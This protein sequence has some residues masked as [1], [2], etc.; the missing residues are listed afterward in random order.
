MREVQCRVCGVHFYT[1]HSRKMTC[2]DACSKEL[3][4]RRKAA[5]RERERAERLH[6]VICVVCGK[7]FETTRKNKKT[8][9]TE[10]G[11]KLQR[12]TTR[13]CGRVYREQKRNSAAKQEKRT[14]ENL[15]RINK[16]AREAGMSYGRYVSQCKRRLEMDC[17]G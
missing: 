14:R 15:A 3:E 4:R 11:Q 9:S 16:L 8:C 7:Q 10:C 13:E 2:S 17:F 12:E 1:E 5:E 6:K